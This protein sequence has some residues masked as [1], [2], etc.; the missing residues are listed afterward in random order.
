MAKER[1]ESE[2]E[3]KLGE[4]GRIGGVVGLGEGGFE[5][6]AGVDDKGTERGL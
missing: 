4:G 2:S 5:G 6:G 1:S 3:D